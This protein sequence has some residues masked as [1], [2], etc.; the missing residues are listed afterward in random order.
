MLTIKENEQLYTL[1]LWRGSAVKKPRSRTRRLSRTIARDREDQD[2]WPHT[3]IG[4]GKRVKQR[5]G[6]ENPLSG[7]QNPSWRACR[8]RKS[9]YRKSSHWERTY[10][11]V[12]G[13]VRCE[14]DGCERIVDYGTEGARRHTEDIVPQRANWPPISCLKCREQ[15][16]SDLLRKEVIGEMLA[17]HIVKL[18]QPVK[19]LSGSWR[20]FESRGPLWR[21]LRFLWGVKRTPIKNIRTVELPF[22]TKEAIDSIQTSNGESKSTASSSDSRSDEVPRRKLS[23]RRSKCHHGKQRNEDV[24]RHSSSYVALRIKYRAHSET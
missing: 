8:I 20:G 23:K 18:L 4:L 1:A 24:K 22:A 5:A 15:V 10:D 12:R 21:L 16:T 2:T 17:A 7:P 19:A 14:G 11:R 6:T 9:S 13:Q 3:D